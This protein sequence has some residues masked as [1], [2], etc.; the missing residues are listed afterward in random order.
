MDAASTLIRPEYRPIM[1]ADRVAWALDEVLSVDLD[2]EIG[3]DDARLSAEVAALHRQCSRLAAM[4]A[5]LIAR[6]D[7]R[8][9]WADDGS[10]SASARLA[11]EA[12]LST[13]TARVEVGRARR[14]RSMPETSEALANGAIST[15]HVDLLA[16]AN[17]PW[18][19]TQ[20]DQHEPSLVD[21]CRKL[22]FDHA[23]TAVHYWCQHADAE[24]AEVDGYRID[25]GR[26]ASIGV[27]LDGEVALHAVLDPVG[28]SAFEDELHRLEHGLYLD[29]RQSGCERT[30]RQRRADALVEM[31]YRSR[32]VPAGGLRPRPLVTIL[33]GESSFERVCE[34]AEGVVITPG[35]VVPHLAAAEIERI[36]FDGPDRVMGVSERRKFTGALRRA[37][38]VRDRHCQHRCGCDERASRCD[39]DHIVPAGQGGITSQDN[40][41][42][43]CSTHNRHP[44]KRN[45]RPPPR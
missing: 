20:F 14:L 2:E 22:R 5:R 12:G 10:R 3:D 29:D 30:I 33:V 39:V 23:R 21:H 13:S 28:G 8:R 36:V 4:N 7:A 16:K 25:Q 38:E 35:Q 42:L 43:L 40:G 1:L 11:H 37:V 24:A 15:D 45:P 26:S 27:T 32:T 17:R 31:A 6:W 34:L 19:G 44:A 18:R 41:R 9:V